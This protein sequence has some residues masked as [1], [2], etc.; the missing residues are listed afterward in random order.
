MIT[1]A[2]RTMR[3]PF[4]N[5]LEA[6]GAH[7]LSYWSQSNVTLADTLIEYAGR[8]CYHSTDRMGSAPGFITDRLREGH[9]DIIEHA[10]VTICYEPQDLMGIDCNAWPRINRYT[11]STQDADGLVIVT[12]NLRAWLQILANDQALMPSEAD[13]LRALLQR[14]SPQV[15]GSFADP[16][17]EGPYIPYPAQ[18]WRSVGQAKVTLLAANYEMWNVPGR[19]IAYWDQHGTASFLIEGVS[20]AFSHQMVRY[21]KNFSY[22][23][24]SQ[25]YVDL[26]KGEW[27]AIIPP[28]IANNP[29][30]LDRFN[31][32]CADAE[33][34]YADLRGMGIRKEDSRFL[35][36]N[37]TET[38]MVVSGSFEA[39]KH[40]LWQRAL[41]KAAQWEIR[42]VGQAILK[43]LWGMAPDVFD[44]EMDTLIAMPEKD[45]V[46][47][48]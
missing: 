12:A 26:V 17:Y 43:T 28:A 2:H 11:A 3:N 6:L 29:Q 18:V 30:A 46:A 10:S 22:S 32:F 42:H 14:V 48:T 27:Q 31:T 39:W 21:R 8:V 23:Q 5:D 37:A 41:D 40:F 38:R 1:I 45:K 44:R 24:E 15:F 25:R 9:E 4:L 20:R 7:D 35:L 47:L 13:R 34:A 36:L 19:G 16:F 33:Q